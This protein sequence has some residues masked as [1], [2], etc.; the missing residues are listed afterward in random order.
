MRYGLESPTFVPRW[1]SLTTATGVASDPVPAVVGTAMS[2]RIGPGTAN[3][4]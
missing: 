4:P 3:S 2:G 1:A